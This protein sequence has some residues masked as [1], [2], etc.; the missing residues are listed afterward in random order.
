[1]ETGLVPPE[2]V[3][4]VA[5]LSGQLEIEV[6]RVLPLERVR[7]AEYLFVA[8]VPRRLAGRVIVRLR[9][10]QTLAYGPSTAIGLL[11]RTE[12]AGGCQG[13]H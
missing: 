13:H 2:R 11:E 4:D 3:G 6:I 1:V 7:A 5:V 10:D 12:G 8:I 9:T